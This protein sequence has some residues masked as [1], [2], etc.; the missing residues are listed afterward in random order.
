M[1]TNPDREN[2]RCIGAYGPIALP[3]ILASAFADVQEFSAQAVS[4]LD[5]W[6]ERMNRA[7][8]R[9]REFPELFPDS[10]DW[11]TKAEAL[12]R[13]VCQT[14]VSNSCDFFTYGCPKRI[15]SLS[16]LHGWAV[17]HQKV[18]ELLP[19]AGPVHEWWRQRRRDAGR[20][21]LSP[22]QLFDEAHAW[23]SDIDP[24]YWLRHFARHS[25]LKSFRYA[26]LSE[27]QKE[28]DRR[29]EAVLDYCRE[30]VSQAWKYLRALHQGLGRPYPSA[31]DKLPDQHACLAAFDRVVN[32]CLEQEDQG[33]S[34]F[35]PTLGPYAD[36]GRKAPSA[37]PEPGRERAS[38]TQATPPEGEGP[39][40]GAPTST[41]VALEGSPP[42]EAAYQFQQIGTI[43]HVRFGEGFGTFPHSKGFRH[44]ANLL[45]SPNQPIEA[46]ELVGKT[47]RPSGGVIQATSALPDALVEIPFTRET[48]QPGLDEEARQSYKRRLEDIKDEINEA[49]E[50]GDED[51]VEGLQS[52]FQRVLA[53][54]QSSAGLGGR[55]RP[56]GP[57]YPAE[58]ARQAVHQALARAKKTLANATPPLTELVEHLEATIKAEGT[59]F[60]YYPKPPAPGWKL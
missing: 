14:V 42:S 29:P 12:V 6:L 32:W 9:V 7:L 52:E 55:I 51:R 49:R 54:L 53:E 31:P 15:E 24:R 59:T 21:P 13:D 41:P 10:P 43:W 37:L 47:G 36:A 46:L 58:K 33:S 25:K 28:P 35:A 26:K 1:A 38:T 8:L 34:R 5:I 39:E 19:D 56:L 48:A 40:H 44:M 11:R 23:L 60:A 18:V 20:Q 45:G 50:E 57:S 17:L 16:D 30:L 3:G 22:E 4:A 2:L 27:E